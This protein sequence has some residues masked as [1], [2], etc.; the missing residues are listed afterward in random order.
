MARVSQKQKQAARIQELEDALYSII[1][2]YK[3]IDTEISDWAIIPVTVGRLR[4]LKGIY[5]RKLTNE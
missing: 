4:K 2:D 5:D 1:N 3:V